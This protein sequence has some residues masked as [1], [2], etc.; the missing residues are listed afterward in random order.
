MRP[1]ISR[2]RRTRHASAVPFAQGRQAASR[3]HPDWAG[4]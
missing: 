3:W 2:N 4:L 1:A